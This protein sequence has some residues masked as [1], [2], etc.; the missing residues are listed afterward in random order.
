MPRIRKV[1]V[2]EPK[3]HD[4]I[5]SVTNDLVALAVA[6][7]IELNL[8]PRDFRK[9]CIQARPSDVESPISKGSI[10]CRSGWYSFR[11][12]SV[13]IN[14]YIRWSLHTQVELKA[15]ARRQ[16]LIDAKTDEVRVELTKR[17][18]YE[19]K[20]ISRQRRKI[21]TYIDESVEEP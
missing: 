3:N 2:T 4:E 19:R 13:L 9:K 6:S 16:E 10:H 21:L 12:Y 8:D 11:A 1:K 7:G 20:T 18:R 17:W 5:G 15:I 14:G